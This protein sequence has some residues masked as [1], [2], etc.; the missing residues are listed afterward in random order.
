VQHRRALPVVSD[1]FFPSPHSHSRHHFPCRHHSHRKSQSMTVDTPTEDSE[2][3]FHTTWKVSK[4]RQ[5]IPLTEDSGLFFAV[6]RCLRVPVTTSVV[7]CCSVLI[8]LSSVHIQK[9]D[10]LDD[11]EEEPEQARTIPKYIFTFRIRLQ[12]YTV[13][14]N[15]S[16]VQTPDL[17]PFQQDLLRQLARH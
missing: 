5:L 17:C 6:V 7:I 16:L 10:V 4:V 12:L 15:S 9:S 3:F 11:S 2:L 8:A 13:S 1:L 14:Q